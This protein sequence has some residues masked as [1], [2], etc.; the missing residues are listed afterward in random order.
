MYRPSSGDGG[1]GTKV[2]GARTSFKPKRYATTCEP[3]TFVL[4]YGDDDLGLLRT[5]KVRKG[6]GEN[7]GGGGS[8][9][10]RRKHK[11]SIFDL[12]TDPLSRLL[13]HSFV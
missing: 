11:R 9:A 10:T 7:G 2:G 3:P 6:W 8:E 4:E 1:F 5:R 13:F 12:V